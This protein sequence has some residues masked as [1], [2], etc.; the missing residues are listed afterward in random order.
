MSFSCY[1]AKTVYSL[2]RL[3]S[4]SYV[5]EFELNC[6]YSRSEARFLGYNT[7]IFS[8]ITQHFSDSDRLRRFVLITLANNN[9]TRFSNLSQKA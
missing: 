1:S 8:K 9:T 7:S 5:D 3:L 4:R 6:I 2:L